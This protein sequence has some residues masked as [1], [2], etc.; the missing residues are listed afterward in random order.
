MID[1]NKTHGVLSPWMHA[2]Q[3]AGVPAV[4]DALQVFAN[5]ASFDNATGIIVAVLANAA[6][7]APVVPAD[8]RAAFVGWLS[9]SYPLAYDRGEAER[10]WQLNHV[11]ALS[12]QA[13]ARLADARTVSGY[14]CAE[15][16]AALR[17]GYACNACFGDE[18]NDGQR[19]IPVRLDAPTVSAQ[20]AITG[21][22]LST[23]AG[24][25]GYVAEY[26]SKHLNRH[27]F[28]RYITERLAA[29]FACALAAHLNSLPAASTPPT[30][31]ADAELVPTYLVNALKAWTGSEPS[32]SVLARAVDQWLDPAAL[33]EHDRPDDPASTGAAS[34]GG[35]S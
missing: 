2:E 14:V 35:E 17:T 20:P 5:D 8:E 23:S 26:F 18:P 28:G 21:H 6:P 10:L 9:A 27:D 33:W 31:A 1:Q 11:A 13:R 3:L 16:K 30:S 32:V 4:D 34:A 29:D 7:Q 12:W 19:Q 15:C 24:G 22:N 25:R